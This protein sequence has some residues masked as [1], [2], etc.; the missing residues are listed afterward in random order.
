M[1]L[2]KVSAMLFVVLYF[3]SDAALAEFYKCKDGKEIKYQQKPCFTP[4]VDEETKREAE[5]INPDGKEV[6]IHEV[7]T[8]KFLYPQLDLPYEEKIKLR[9]KVKITAVGILTDWSPKRPTRISVYDFNGNK[10]GEKIGHENFTKY[11]LDICG[12]SYNAA[13]K[14]PD[15]RGSTIGELR[16]EV[17]AFTDSILIRLNGMLRP[18]NKY[19]IYNGVRV[20]GVKEKKIT[21]DYY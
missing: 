1:N 20:Y 17:T 19:A 12:Y 3:A 5:K 21:E 16:I 2:I 6:L 15:E 4:V 9:D 7:L 18:S 10:K 11:L 13:C 8:N 14:S